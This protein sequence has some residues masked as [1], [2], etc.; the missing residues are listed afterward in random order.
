MSSINFHF[1]KSRIRLESDKSQM[2]P[3][4]GISYLREELLAR[5]ETGAEFQL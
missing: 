2:A 4:G 3:Q 1:D 5:D